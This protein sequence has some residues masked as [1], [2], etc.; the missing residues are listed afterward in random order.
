[1]N[2]LT[3]ID[4]IQIII[5]NINTHKKCSAAQAGIRKVEII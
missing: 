4:E 5:Y 1:M 2:N 3:V